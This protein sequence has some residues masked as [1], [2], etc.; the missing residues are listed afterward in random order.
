MQ[1]IQSKYLI[2]FVILVAI[3]F[4]SNYKGIDPDFGWHLIKVIDVRDATVLPFESV[5]ENLRD[6]L[7][8]NKINEINSRITKDIKIKILSKEGADSKN[9]ESSKEEVS[10]EENIDEDI[11]QAVNEIISGK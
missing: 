9:E 2:L 3:A 6:Q 10:K 11:D 5:K 7:A 8:Q 1:K 4:L